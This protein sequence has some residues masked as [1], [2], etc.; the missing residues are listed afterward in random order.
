MPTLFV[1]GRHCTMAAL[2]YFAHA[3][4]P[5]G[6][7]AAQLTPGT[8][9]HKLYDRLFIAHACM[10]SC[11]VVAERVPGIM[12]CG[13]AAAFLLPIPMRLWVSLPLSLPG[14]L[15]HELYC[16]FSLLMPM[17]L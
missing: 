10:P 2:P 15:Y 17:Y 4:V 11:T 5:L 8:L 14:T 16:H 7:A 9:C 13:Y 3:F 6:A 12:Y 1:L